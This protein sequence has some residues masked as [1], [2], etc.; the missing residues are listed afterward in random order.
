[1]HLDTLTTLLTKTVAEQRQNVCERIIETPRIKIYLHKKLF[2][3]A[4]LSKVIP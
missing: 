3:T 1:M 2:A 4:I